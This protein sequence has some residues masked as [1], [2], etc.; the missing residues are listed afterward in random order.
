MPAPAS[1]NTIG[2]DFDTVL[3]LLDRS[4]DGESLICNDDAYFGRH[5]SLFLWRPSVNLRVYQGVS[6]MLE[7]ACGLVQGGGQF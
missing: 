4:C 1:I 5:S 6:V 2:S 7:T 3:Y